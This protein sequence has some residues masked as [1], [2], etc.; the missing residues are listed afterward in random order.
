MI[1][2]YTKLFHKSISGGKNERVGLSDFRRLGGADSFAHL[3]LASVKSPQ[4]TSNIDWKMLRIKSSIDSRSFVE[5]TFRNSLL[6]H[7]RK[8]KNS[9]CGVEMCVFQKSIPIITPIITTYQQ[10]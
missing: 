7:E 5:Q 2:H 8:L 10:A 9:L 3:S 4:A 6:W 1:H